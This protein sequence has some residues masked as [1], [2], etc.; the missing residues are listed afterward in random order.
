MIRLKSSVFPMGAVFLLALSFAGCGSSDAGRVTPPSPPTVLSNTPLNGGTGMALN[1]S[2]SVTFNKAMDPASLSSATFILTS[3]TP[4]VAVAGTVIY[5]KSKVVFWPATHLA[6]NR[7]YTATVT[8]GAKSDAGVAL[9]ANHVWSFTTGTTTAAG[10]PVNLGTAS[11]YVILAKS[12]P[13]YQAFS[14]K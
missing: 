9:T 13:D 4:A 8:T 5:A 3:G 14:A 6:S 7:L 12:G 2:A 10:L 11:A 1:E